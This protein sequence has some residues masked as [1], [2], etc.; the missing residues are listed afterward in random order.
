MN[1]V[2]LYALTTKDDYLGIYFDEVPNDWRVIYRVYEVLK[3]LFG[4]VELET[5]EMGG[6]P[7]L[8]FTIPSFPNE[9]LNRIMEGAFSTSAR[10]EG[11][12]WVRWEF[13]V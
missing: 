6:G 2:G 11:D 13:E 12:T 10:E 3:G 5:R 7:I 4:S 9:E 8:Y 1:P